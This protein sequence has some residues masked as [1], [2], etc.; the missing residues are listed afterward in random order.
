MPSLRFL[1]PILT[2]LPLQPLAAA[3][4]SS[5]WHEAEGGAIRIVTSGTPD[6]DGRLR[7]ALEIRL[8]PGWKTYWLDPG[9]SGV[10]PV[11]DV[12]ADGREAG[13]EIGFP[14]PQ[15]L[16]DGYARWAG[17][18]GT[19]S[20]ALTF[21]LPAGASAVHMQA[22]AFLGICETICV[23][24]QASL[25]LDPAVSADDP[26]HEAVVEAAFASLPPAARDDLFASVVRAGDGALAVE[27]H[28]PDGVEVIDLFVAGTDRLSLDTPERLEGESRPTFKVPFMGRIDDGADGLVYTLVTS[29]GA[30]TGTLALP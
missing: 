29:A 2:V 6:A 4:A 10:P 14:P 15:R 3:A 5:A 21:S 17:Y 30:V 7:G 25:A 12:V 26:Q 13:V 20:F 28:V 11:L 8:Q 23:P 9:S 27:A 19:V 22:S 16:D 18:D 24:V 1:L